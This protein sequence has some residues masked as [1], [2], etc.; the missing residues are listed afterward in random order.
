[1]FTEY[2]NQKRLTNKQRNTLINTSTSE[3]VHQIQTI[4]LLTATSTVNTTSTGSP[5]VL[6]PMSYT[7]FADMAKHK[8]YDDVGL[9]CL[10]DSCGHLRGLST[11]IAHRVLTVTQ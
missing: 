5:E 4:E 9:P 7:T 3:K 11:N 1:M 8:E 10:V 6:A 2:S